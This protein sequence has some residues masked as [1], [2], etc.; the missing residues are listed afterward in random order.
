MDNKHQEISISIWFDSEAETAAKLYTS[1]F[2]ESKMGDITHYGKEGKEVHGQPE[3]KVMT[4]EFTLANLRFVGINGGPIFK[5]NPSISFFVVCETEQETDKLWKSLLNGGQVLMAMDKYAWSEKYG[6]LSDRYGISWQISMGN[7]KD[8]GQK[9]T[10]SIMYTGNQNGRTREAIGFYTSVFGDSSITG[11]LPYEKGDGDT[12][13]NVKHAQFTLS[14][15]TFMAMDSSLP[16]QFNFDEGV[17]FVVNCHNQEE[18][19]YFWEK[20]TKNGGQESNCGWLKDKFGLSWQV[21]SIRLN[22]MLKDPDKDKTERV[23]K[24]FLQMKKLDLPTL[25][26]AYNG[27]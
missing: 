2:S 1:L 19:D 17:S 15:Q 21:D 12:E 8:T 11:I 7:I 22:E 9:I 14:R 23:T 6:W 26:K 24:A 20:F 16:H 27:E 5:P 18:I 13:G 4:A 10:P 25:E 3:G